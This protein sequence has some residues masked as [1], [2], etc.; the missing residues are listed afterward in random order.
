MAVSTKV[1]QS[2][3]S[4]RKVGSGSSPR[5]SPSGREEVAGAEERRRGGGG[6]GGAGRGGG[7]RG[8]E[9]G[10]G[11]GAQGRAVRSG[12]CRR[13]AGPGSAACGDR[14]EREGQRGGEEVGPDT[15]HGLNASSGTR[16]RKLTVVST[17]SPVTAPL[18][19]FPSRKAT[20]APSTS[21]KSE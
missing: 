6:A 7:E 4:S 11:A 17:V 3:A 10:L 18:A 19:Q 1:T 16:S 12:A 13:G 14:A 15:P 2:K 21:R 5:P 9:G 8:L 20:R